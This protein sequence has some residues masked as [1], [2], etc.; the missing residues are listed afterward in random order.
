MHSSADVRALSDGVSA[1]SAQKYGTGLEVLYKGWRANAKAAAMTASKDYA[2]AGRFNPLDSVDRAEALKTLAFLRATLPAAPWQGPARD[3]Q[4]EI[5]K[6]LPDGF[7]G[8]VMKALEKDDRKEGLLCGFAQ[9]EAALGA[10]EK[11]RQQMLAEYGQVDLQCQANLAKLKEYEGRVL[12]DA[13]G[14][15]LVFAPGR[16]SVL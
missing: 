14:V 9:Y 10:L 16:K 2:V 15:G 7:R 3:L 1:A 11:D 6:T 5:A 13:K 8:A 12:L 4:L